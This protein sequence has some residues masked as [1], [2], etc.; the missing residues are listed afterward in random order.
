[1]VA[2]LLDLGVGSTVTV[3]LNDYLKLTYWRVIT[4]KRGLSMISFEL[5]SFFGVRFTL[6][7]S[8]FDFFYGSSFT[9]SKASIWFFGDTFAEAIREYAI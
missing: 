2:A 3:A 6:T 7:F 1:M 8:T 4:S 9:S 5:C